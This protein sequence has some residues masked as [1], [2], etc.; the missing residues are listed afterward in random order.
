L[1]FLNLVPNARL[2]IGIGL[3]GILQVIL[4]YRH[5]INYKIKRNLW[6][7]SLSGI[8]S[9]IIMLLVGLSLR[10]NFPVYVGGLTSLLIYITMV[11]LAIFLIVQQY[12]KTGLLVLILFSLF[13]VYRVFPWYV[14]LSPITNTSVIESIKTSSGVD[15]I[16]VVNGSYLL[17]ENFPQLAGRKSFSGNNLY[18]QLGLWRQID[19]TNNYENVYNRYA[20]VQFSEKEEK[21]FHL[22]QADIFVVGYNPCSGF[23]NKNVNFILSSSAMSAPCLIL[24]NTISYPSQKFYIYKIIN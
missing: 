4:F 3:L 15:D 21:A 9:F 1:L 22:L 12:F 10:S 7:S 17:A 16:W 5:I 2:I 24:K 6:L 18:P 14:G 13:S 8:G 20:H 11:S 19:K 23:I